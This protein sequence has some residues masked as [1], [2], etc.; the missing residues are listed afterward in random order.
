MHYQIREGDEKTRLSM[1]KKAEVSE[2]R[3]ELKKI[4]MEWSDL[5]CESRMNQ[6]LMEDQS[7]TN[8]Q[9]NEMFRMQMIIEQSR[10]QDLIYMKYRISIHDLERVAQEMKI[11]EDEDVKQLKAQKYEQVEKMEKE[12]D[13][14]HALTE[15]EEKLL[16]EVIAHVGKISHGGKGGLQ[17]NFEDYKRIVK[18]MIMFG[19]ELNWLN[20]KE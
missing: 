1:R 18:I 5:Q 13:E 20:E 2:S 14:K 15:D 8:I 10:V 16:K 12:L 3:D 4:Y 7:A 6:I 19:E 9:S 17:L 11:T